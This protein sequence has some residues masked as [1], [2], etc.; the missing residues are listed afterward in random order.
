MRILMMAALV[1]FAPSQHVD[2]DEVRQDIRNVVLTYTIAGPM[3]LDGIPDPP[4]PDE[5]VE[6]L[7]AE[8]HRNVRIIL[9][10]AERHQEPSGII[11]LLGPATIEHQ[12][13]DGTLASSEGVRSFRIDHTYIRVQAEDAD[14][15][16][17]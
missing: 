17:P 9:E 1:G 4:E 15:R 12:L 7:D 3:I 16:E 10:S 14:D 6:A 8:D 2:A 5:V 13:Y 11:P